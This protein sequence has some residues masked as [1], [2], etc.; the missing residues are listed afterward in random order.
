MSALQIRLDQLQIHEKSGTYNLASPEGVKWVISKE[1]RMG[2][3]PYHVGCS[4]VGFVNAFGSK[5]LRHV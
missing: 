5:T 3:V 4:L 1:L 2:L